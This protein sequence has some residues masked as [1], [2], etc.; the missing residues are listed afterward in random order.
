MLV[1]EDVLTKLL[2]PAASCHISPITEDF[3]S[4]TTGPNKLV[5]K[6][7]MVAFYLSPQQKVMSVGPLGQRTERL[8]A[9][10]KLRVEEQ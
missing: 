10:G 8:F 4:E 1:R 9:V 7:S 5:Q 3:P 2:A 6:T